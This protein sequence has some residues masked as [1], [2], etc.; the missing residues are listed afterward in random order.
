MSA[1]AHVHNW[2]LFIDCKS[3]KIC[4]VQVLY[5]RCGLYSIGLPPPHC[6][7]PSRLS[8]LPSPLS[9]FF[10]GKCPL[11]YKIWAWRDGLK[12][13]HTCCSGRS[14]SFCICHSPGGSQ[15]PVIR[16]PENPAPPLASKHLATH[17]AQ[18]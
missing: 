3:L 18:M 16:V 4:W 17:G 11:N 13:K 5:Q 12:V 10:L 8:S 15:S 7:P 2:V 9:S 1:H 6:L 14:L